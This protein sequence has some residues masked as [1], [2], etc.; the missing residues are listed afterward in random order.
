MMYVDLKNIVLK[1]CD[2]YKFNNY[3][4][5]KN[6][7]EKNGI[8]L[9]CNQDEEDTLESSHSILKHAIDLAIPEMEL[10]TYCSEGYPIWITRP[11]LN[12]LGSK[13]SEV[14]EIFGISKDKMNYIKNWFDILLEYSKCTKQNWHNLEGAWN[15]T[16][17]E[18]INANTSLKVEKAYVHLINALEAA[19]SKESCENKYRV[20]LYTSILFSDEKD[21]RKRSFEL[22]KKAYDIRSKISNEIPLSKDCISVESL[23]SEYFEL[24]EIVST[25]LLKTYKKEKTD[26]IEKIQDSIFGCSGV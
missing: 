17:N 5:F 26:I 13:R 25:I 18:Y 20:S 7:S 22:V 1:D 19:L 3:F 12:T 10:L 14:K 4:I 15:L 16:F 23:Y 6:N 9:E 2:E 24:K 11:L 8:N 21:K